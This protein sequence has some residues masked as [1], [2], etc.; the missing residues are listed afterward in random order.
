M[1]KVIKPLRSGQITIP[2]EFREKLGIDTDTILQM[3]LVQGELRIKPI[4]ATK[5][6]AGSAWLKELYEYFAPVREEAKKKGYS[7]KEING[8]IDQALKAVRKKHAKSS[9]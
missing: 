6:V 4:Q 2:A 9:F 7:E 1:N 8:H 5:T 3:S